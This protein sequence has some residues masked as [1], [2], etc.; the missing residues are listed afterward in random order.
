MVNPVERL[1]KYKFDL[2]IL[3]QRL[4]SIRTNN[5]KPSLERISAFPDFKFLDLSL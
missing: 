4:Q 3:L 1:K 2:A 5:W